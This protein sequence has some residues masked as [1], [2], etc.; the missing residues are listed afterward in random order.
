MLLTITC[1]TEQATDLG[2]LLH[3]NPTNVFS[4]RLWFGEV[5]V[6]YPEVEAK[7]CTVALLLDVDPVGW[8]RGNRRR[9]SGLDQYVNDRPYV[10][11]SLMSVAIVTAFG[12]ALNGKSR[13]RPERVTEKM[14]LRVRL[15]AVRCMA[16]ED[17]I[18]RL[19]VPLGYTVTLCR[20]P[21]DDRFPAWG[22]SDLYA[23]TLEGQQTVQDLLTQL[24]LL[25]PVLDNF[26]HYFVSEEEIEKLLQKGERWLASHPDREL[27]TR[28]YLNYRQSMVREALAQLEALREDSTETQEEADTLAEAQ[29]LAVEEPLRLQDAR[30]QAALEA[31]RSLAPSA[32]RILDLG[33][34]EGQLLRLLLREPSLTEIVGVDVASHTLERAAQRLHLDT[35]PERQKARIRLLQG[36]VVYRDDRFQNFDVALLIEVIEH[37]DPPRLQAMEQVVFRHAAPVRVVIST[38]NADYNALWPS[39]PAGRFRHRDHRFEWS[40]AEFQAWASQ[41]AS[42]F[43]YSVAFQGI[44]PEDVEQGCPTQMAI[45]DRS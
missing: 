2:Y 40:R 42:T 16:G 12:S 24:Y 37:L 4:E 9:P 6:F 3:K 25:I 19:F 23:V 29:E 35:L 17:L 26:K 1:E 18:Q 10:A 27:I 28:R 5:M 34:G 32:K 38:P 14:A 31:V 39:L 41:V 8:V 21:L 44:G 30:M 7:R 22:E 45:F 33:C 36:S 11:S 43:G 15:A 13:E 20:E